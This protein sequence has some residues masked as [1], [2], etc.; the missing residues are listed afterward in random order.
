MSVQPENAG[1]GSRLT[2]AR[3]ALLYATFSVLWIVASGALLTLTVDD[4]A[5]QH[6]IEV[7]KG[8]LFVLVTTGLLYFLLRLWRDPAGF[9]AD[10]NADARPRR[11]LRRAAGLLG[12]IL[13]VPLAGFMVTRVHGPQ[14][15]REAME[16]LSAIA[17]LQ[18]RQLENWLDERRGDGGVLMADAEFVESVQAL[19]ASGSPDARE[20][21]RRRLMPF[22]DAVQY[23]A[24]QVVGSNGDVLTQ[25]GTTFPLSARTRETLPIAQQSWQTLLGEIESDE[26]GEKM[27]D[28]VVPLVRFGTD[29]MRT[30][31][32]CVV[33]R[34]RVDASMMT[35]IRHW[36]TA[37]KSGTTV[38]IRVLGDEVLVLGSSRDSRDAGIR[39]RTLIK[40][41][42]A[43]ESTFHNDQAGV[44]R[45]HDP[46]G[47]PIIAAFRKVAGTDWVL[48]AKIKYEEVQSP[49]RALAFWVSL[50]AFVALAVIGA[51]TLLLLRQRERALRLE[52]AAQSDRILRRF[53]DLPFIGIAVCS[54]TS[55]RLL[56]CND[57]LCEIFGSS[58]QALIETA[59]E[60]WL[61]ADARSDTYREFAR[62]SAGK[63]DGFTH[64]VR[65][66]RPD[67]E[68]VDAAM[69]VRSLRE[70]DSEVEYLV[71]TVQDVTE[72]RRAA[73]SI[74]RLTGV[75]A[76]LSE[77]NQAIV[78]CRT[79]ESLFE[80]VCRIAITYGGIDMAWIGL[81]DAATQRVMP[82]ARYGGSARFLDRFSFSIDPAS[83]E[84]SLPTS[85]AV[86]ELRPCWVQDTADDPTLEP[87]R[88]LAKQSGFRSIAALP[89]IRDGGAVG[90]FVLYSSIPGFFDD[91]VRVLLNKMAQ[92][93]GLAL[94]RFA[95]EDERQK[96]ET[97]LRES[98]GRFR[99]LYEKAPL[100]YLLLDAEGRIADANQAWLSFLGLALDQVIG[101]YVGEFLVDESAQSLAAELPMIAQNGR[102]DGILLTFRH[103]DGSPRLTMLNAQAS[104]DRDGRL[105][106]IHCILTDL[107]ERQKSAE[108]LRLAAAVFEQSAEG[109]VIT[110]L[111]RRI[112]M[113]NKAFAQITGYS[114]AELIGASVRMLS[115]DEDERALEQTIRETLDRL[116]Y[117]QGEVWRRRKNGEV[118][119]A[120]GSVSRVY[121][122][123]GRV[124]H[125]VGIFSDISERRS[126]EEKI[127]R[128]AHFDPLTGLP[129]RSLL[130][131]RVGQA[132]SR[133]ARFGSSLALIF[134]DLDRFKN[135]NDS[136]GH[137]IGDKLLVLVAERLKLALR[138][139]DTVSRLGG[140][141][142]I[143]VL[144]D[145]DEH[146]A[147]HVV[148][149]VMKEL[150]QPYAIEQHEL[151]VTPSLGIALYPEDGR[152][153]ETL[154]RC[155]DTAMYRAKQS[156]RNTFRFF[157]R[158]MQERSERT[159]VLENALRRVFDGEQL[160]LQ[161]QPQMSLV[162]GRLV[163]VEALLR[164]RHPELGE[165]SPADFVPI[166][167]ENGLI[168]PI[169]EWVLRKAV[170]QMRA[171][172]DM[173]M[174]PL[175]MAVNL[176]AV[177]FHQSN[178]TELIKRVLS[179]SGL[180][181]ECLE[182]ELTEGVAMDNPVAAIAVM[183][184]LAG[185]GVKMSID[186]F[187][188]GYSSL[189]YLK[190]F[191]VS[192]L[193]IDQS[194]VRD[195]CTD[196]E[197]AAIIETII[198]LA[199]NLGLKAIAEGVES[200]EQ[201]AFLRDRD[202]DE[203]Q[204]Y[205]ISR[206]MTASAFEAFVRTGGTD[207]SGR[208]PN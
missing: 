23:D 137:R 111:A 192:K 41:D 107:T 32:G 120:Q 147:T 22:V 35:N 93:M 142:F 109:I 34:V 83:D 74:Q 207:F 169:G 186:D 45:T 130:E 12:M 127:H 119:P 194:F 59:W 19:E 174:P 128:L 138:D 61:S 129:N 65:F 176:S 168:L 84:A 179:E 193:K 113:V 76:A 81:V 185:H 1:R 90:A 75:Y 188:T 78:Q 164:W 10:G 72:A 105:L 171:W 71:A 49:V 108:Q 126:A 95:H 85:R 37:S 2:P 70:P 133:V 101:N 46:D 191:R 54:P 96:M 177:Q 180:P 29:G 33:L 143:L 190:R 201:L 57:R 163:G 86:R 182:L 6:Q 153:Y 67:G 122:A 205:L 204:G 118:F 99:D 42:A 69:V 200:A 184:E 172:L 8:L 189:N 48:V 52:M 103:A 51:M 165:I 5:L 141:E 144:P 56:Q 55:M 62:V 159:L 25:I 102:T 134:L 30:P 181:P 161:Y 196:P 47:T 152:D 156:G 43:A 26:S 170:G 140:D 104:H 166:A 11:S 3:V 31:V 167:E 38:L 64:D 198:G 106:R 63:A 17:D 131:D 139:E 77:C 158:D 148:E 157:T 97:A 14:V 94:V 178:L 39:R 115:V 195:C 112:L 50:V 58:R 98:E 135:I 60:K 136:L 173:G 87:W 27:L 160:S 114:E 73:D 146:G 88:K 154:S 44:L 117:W 21:I 80:E 145:T 9:K 132:L 66:E 124:T 18:A 24:A 68:T 175:V 4:E 162:D 206:P 40:G 187:G 100:P 16:N 91:T 202:C 89:L 203:V 15:E 121:D 82:V 53:Y 151:I 125:L 28:F 149:K 20:V 199:R 13:V 7:G 116:G 150:A 155:A 36:P 197:D 208:P 123:N 183:E 92:A 110:D 79:A